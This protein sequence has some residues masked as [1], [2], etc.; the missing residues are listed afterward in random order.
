MR[1]QRSFGVVLLAIFILSGV[2]E[3]CALEAKKAQARSERLLWK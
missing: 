1:Q 2:V 3:T